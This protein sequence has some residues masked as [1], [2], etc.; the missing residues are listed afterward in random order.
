[1]TVTSLSRLSNLSV[2]PRRRGFLPLPVFAAVLCFLFLAAAFAAP[3]TQTESRPTGEAKPASDTTPAVETSA[4]ESDKAAEDMAR[5][6][7]DLLARHQGADEERLTQLM[8]PPS[9][10]GTKESDLRLTWRGPAG[11]GEPACRL[12]ATL[13]EGALANVELSGTP[14][15]D[16]KTCRK[17]LRPLLQAMPWKSIEHPAANTDG[18]AAGIVLANETIMQMVKEGLP[19]QAILAR[20]RT[21]ACKFDTS[22]EGTS[23]LRRNNVPEPLI[24][25]ILDRTCT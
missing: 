10:K 25:A 8:G 4:S 22:P 2:A 12:T 16:R 19:S 23:A 3:A 6:R 24:Q 17:F 18:T 20:I 13:V 5:T 1:M 14:S 15:W 9:E 11:D 7:A 21:Q